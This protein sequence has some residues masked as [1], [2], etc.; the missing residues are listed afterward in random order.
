MSHTNLHKPDTPAHA[1]ERRMLEASIG[2]ADYLVNMRR[3]AD[4]KSGCA[5]AFTVTAY[6]DGN[7]SVLIGSQYFGGLFSPLSRAFADAEA[8]LAQDDRALVN[9]TIGLTA[10]GRYRPRLAVLEG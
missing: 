1:E 6:C 10:D 5:N 9:K 4:E 2:V 8:W 7:G 3:R